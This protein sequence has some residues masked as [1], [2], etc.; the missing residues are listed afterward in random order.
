[1]NINIFDYVKGVLFDKIT[2]IEINV[3]LSKFNL[4]DKKIKINTFLAILFVIIIYIFGLF[5]P[6]TI[7][8]SQTFFPKTYEEPQWIAAKVKYFMTRT[9][10]RIIGSKTIEVIGTDREDDDYSN[11]K[12]TDQDLKRIN[13]GRKS[14]S[15]DYSY[16]L[17]MYE[18]QDEPICL[19][20]Y[21]IRNSEK[22]EFKNIIKIKPFLLNPGEKYSELK[23][24]VRDK[25]CLTNNNEPK[26]KTR[27]PK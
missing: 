13:L 26:Y 3:D 27:N 11:L 17:Q 10:N 14:N 6:A 9:Q 12:N 15:A 4:K 7:N 22:T 20:A 2:F 25:R 23:A 16:S 19:L 18:D 24:S 21:G 5:T 1:M 8:Y